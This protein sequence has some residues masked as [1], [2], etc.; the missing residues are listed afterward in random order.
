MYGKQW[1]RNT[2]STK[3]VPPNDNLLYPMPLPP[4][5]ETLKVGGIS[6]A[7]DEGAKA[8]AAVELW[9][10]WVNAGVGAAATLGYTV[11]LTWFHDVPEDQYYARLNSMMN[12]SDCGQNC[13]DVVIVPE[14]TTLT[15]QMIDA[16]PENSSVPILMT[17]ADGDDLYGTTCK[18]E[19]KKPFNC[20]GMMALQSQQMIPTLDAIKNTRFCEGFECDGFSVA[21]VTNSH[22]DS[23]PIHQSVLDWVENVY[24]VANAGEKSYLMVV[25]LAGQFSLSTH[26]GPLPPEDLAVL[27]E[28]LSREPDVI[29]V[30][31]HPGDVE[32]TIIKLRSHP[33]FKAKAIVAVNAFVNKTKYA[34]LGMLGYLK[35]VISPEQWAEVPDLRDSLTKWTSDIFKDKMAEAGQNATQHAASAAAAVLAVSHALD[36][37]VGWDRRSTFLEKLK[38][39]EVT[40]T[41]YGPV[42]FNVDGSTTKPMYGMQWRSRDLQVAIPPYDNL[43]YP[44]PD[45]EMDGTTYGDTDDTS[46]AALVMPERIVFALT[47]GFVLI[48]GIRFA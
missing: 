47:V 1:D 43:V 40:D 35:G 36:A 4:I 37:G 32:E 15:R 18:R 8:K 22:P 20:F 48:A 24:N 12:Y 27:D 2:E 45:P 33:S 26:G 17:G 42:S 34:D 9:R 41:F 44:M 25:D 11:D 10:D 3:T 23:Q 21:A 7:T 5:P 13:V 38:G 39:L 19:H 16:M 46:A 14:T 31:G 6:V 29:T 30:A 28:V